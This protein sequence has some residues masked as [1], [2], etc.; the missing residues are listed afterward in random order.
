MA[1][2][3]AGVWIHVYRLNFEGVVCRI[4]A[5]SDWRVSGDK[6]S[7]TGFISGDSDLVIRGSWSDRC[8]EEE[9]EE[10]SMHVFW[11]EYFDSYGGVLAVA[12]R[13]G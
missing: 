1:S 12:F 4:A 8:C 3:Y 2:H 7:I 10:R 9:S 6:A 13:E 5:V 11:S